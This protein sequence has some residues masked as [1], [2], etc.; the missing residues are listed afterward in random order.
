MH[1]HEYEH[2]HHHPPVPFSPPVQNAKKQE[3]R[4]YTFIF[5]ITL[6][7]G[8]L[9]IASG[10]FKSGAVSLLGDGT[11][12]I[13]DGF[14]YGMLAFVLI[15][16]M[17]HPEQELYWTKKGVWI[18]FWLLALGDFFV[19]WQAIERFLSPHEVLGWWTFYTTAFCLLI[20]A[21]VVWVMYRL[22]EKE[23]NIRHDSVLFHALSDAW[24]S[25]GVLIS[26]VIIINTG[27]YSAD[28]IMA[29]VIAFYLLFLL[30]KLLERIRKEDWRI[31]HVHEHDHEEEGEEKHEHRHSE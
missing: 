25:V 12:G 5:V 26:S 28:W 3:L 21:F 11:H 20:N 29:F 22:P 2:C 4:L 31:G 15:K 10:Y 19:F 24:V 23:H 6:F 27:W 9:E 30:Y 16:I 14:N 8:L 13:S 1:D 18:S 17:N 7:A